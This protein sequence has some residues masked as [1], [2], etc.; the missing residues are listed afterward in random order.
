MQ[1]ENKSPFPYYVGVHSLEDLANKNSKVIVLNILGGESSTVTP[2]SHE[3]SG[4]NVVAGVQY[5]RGGSILETKKGD[6]PVF[7]S[8]A[9]IVK[10]GI[11]FDTGVVYLPPSAVSHAVSELCAANIDLQRIV[12]VTEKIAVKDARY[13]RYGAQN[14]RVDV[15]GANSLGVANTWDQVR[16]GGALGGDKP[17]ESLKKG[18]VAI[19]SNSGNFSTTMAEYLKTA[20][21]GTS[22]IV[23]SGKDI[24]IHYAFPEFLYAAENDPRTKVVVAYIEPGGY[25]EKQAIDWINENRFKFTKP[26]VVVVTGRW[27]KHLTRAVGH[28]GAIAGGGDD[29]EAKEGWFDTYFGV[30]EFNPEKPNVS[31][32]GV[33]VASIQDVPTAVAAVMTKLGQQPDFA[34][35]GDLSLKPWFVNDQGLALPGSLRMDAVQAMAPYDAEIA[36]ANKQV[37]AQLIRQNMRNKSGASYMNKTTDVSMLHETSLLDLVKHP[38]GATAL[39]AVTKSMPS[40]TQMQI[41]NPIMNF[42]THMG[43][44]YI[45]VAI[46]SRS[47][48]ASPNAYIG[49]SVMVSGNNPFYQALNK[50]AVALIDTFFEKIGRSSDIRNEIVADAV[51]SASGFAME[52]GVSEKA[53]QIAD[54]LND[55]LKKGGMENI[56]TRFASEY[57]AKMKGQAERP[58]PA[59]LMINAIL[60]GI[61]WKPLTDKQITRKDAEEFGVYLA[62]NGVIVGSAA[63]TGESNQFWKGLRD[64]NDLNI[65]KTDFAETCFR[66]LF[67][68]DPVGQEI[69]AFNSL[70]N[71]TVTNGPGTISAKGAKESVS[72]RNHIATAFAGFM[73]NTGFAHGGNGFEAVEFLIEHFG[74]EDPYKLERNQ[75]D[76]KL[77]PVAKK[78]ADDYIVYKKQAKAKGILDYKKIPCTNH[79]VFKGKDFNIDPREDFVRDLFKKKNMEN[80]FLEFYHHL[81]QKLFDVGATRNV[82]CVNIDAVIATISLELF[83]KQFKAGELKNKDMMDI[84]FTMFLFGRMVG[85]SA[86]ISDHRNRGTDMDCR[87]P[88]SEV[89]YVK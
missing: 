29:A 33:R 62:V 38:F 81:V 19:Y 44:D 68:R 10:A 76:S 26:I 8:V 45:D 17:G 12:I 66:V 86:E 46:R 1:R 7:G 31:E 65:L 69:F 2:I 78:V 70:M 55:I 58:N 49:S 43:T 18:S 63:V 11:Q 53:D 61:A 3:Y 30:G 15:V 14:R 37:G 39:F 42:M 50:N 41:I 59:T 47:N 82:F 60:M 83:W 9:E 57:N 40:D 87:T 72:A 71:L 20:G 6:I 24:Y 67:S 32:K 84:V 13:I 21:F 4:G 52:S 5:G 88:A 75:W 54:F 51:A 27:K 34:P 28:A 74:N 35:I 36:E 23:S 64:L 16:I 56:F 48:G 89:V 22:T 79:P 25:Y 77:E 85:S 73:T 80:P